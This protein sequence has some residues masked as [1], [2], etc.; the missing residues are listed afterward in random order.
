MPY[1]MAAKPTPIVMG[2]IVARAPQGE[3]VR[4]RE[5]VQN[6][7]VNER[8]GCE[9]PRSSSV[10]MDQGGYFVV[11]WQSEIASGGEIRARRFDARC[12]SPCDGRGR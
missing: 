11:A 6:G 3:E 10:A 5:F 9:I 4:L 2:F 8:S 1:A 12:P 7:K